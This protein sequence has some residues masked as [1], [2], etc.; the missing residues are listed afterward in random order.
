[1]VAVQLASFDD[2]GALEAAADNIVDG[3]VIG[4]FFNGAYAFLGDADRIDAAEEIFRL[5][6]RPREQTLS[7]V[8]DPRYWGEFVDLDAACLLYT[9][10]SP[11][12][13]L[14]SRMPSSA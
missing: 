5:K 7:L 8:T 13:G 12:D 3:R 14:L 11:R 9:S 2:P 6:R 1:M 4:F 10:P